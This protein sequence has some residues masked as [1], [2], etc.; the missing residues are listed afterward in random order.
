M[1]VIDDIEPSSFVA[2]HVYSLRPGSV[3]TSVEPLA[4]RTVDPSFHCHS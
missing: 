3:S 4:I 2:V 1:F